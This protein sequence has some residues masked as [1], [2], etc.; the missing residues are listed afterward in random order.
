MT[1]QCIYCNE[2]KDTRGFTAHERACAMKLMEK[3][4]PRQFAK[5]HTPEEAMRFLRKAPQ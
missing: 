3:K 4:H 5:M 1:K 2:E